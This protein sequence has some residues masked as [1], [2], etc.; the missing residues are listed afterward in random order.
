M[1][2]LERAICFW[3]IRCYSGALEIFE[4]FHYTINSHLVV[5]LE[6]S[7]VLYGQSKCD[8]GLAVLEWLALGV[9]SGVGLEQ[10][11]DS[12]GTLHM[13]YFTIKVLSCWQRIL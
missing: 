5:A 2:H 7:H 1:P 12:V 10:L 6:N 4:A 9:V 8:E 11:A 13:A 3:R